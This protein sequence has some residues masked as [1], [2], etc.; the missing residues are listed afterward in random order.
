MIGRELGRGSFG[1][2]HD[3]CIIDPQTGAQLQRVVAK[4]PLENKDGL[5]Y[6]QVRVRA[7]SIQAKLPVAWE[8]E[9]CRK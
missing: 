3:G 1:V 2:V 5:A 9:S 4:G 8:L 7:H 6:W